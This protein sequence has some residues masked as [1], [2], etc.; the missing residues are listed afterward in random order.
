MW[1]N[2]WMGWRFSA[3]LLALCLLGA[4]PAAGGAPEIS[5]KGGV[6]ESSGKD[7]LEGV[8]SGE[9]LRL[10]GPQERDALSLL[11]GAADLEGGRFGAGSLHRP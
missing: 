8:F 1:K 10:P 11:F 3:A 9:I 5:G 4:P 2:S 6:P 7:V